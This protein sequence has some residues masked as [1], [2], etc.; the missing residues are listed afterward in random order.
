MI[1][2]IGKAASFTDQ[3]ARLTQL[4]DK[5]A[6]AFRARFV[7][8]VRLIR[9]AQT[10]T[11]IENLIAVGRWADALVVVETAML[12][13]GR[14][15]QEAFATAG[16]DTALLIGNALNI[17][18][19]FDTMND[20]ALNAMRQNTLRLVREFGAEQ[21]LATREALEDGIRRGINPR[22]MAREFRDSIGLTRR[23][24]QA[25]NNYRRLLESLD[26]DSLRRLLRDRRFDRT[27]LRAIEEGRPLSGKQIETMVE[28]Y[29]ARYLKYRSEVIG[30]TEAL[31]SVHAGADAMY[32]QAIADGTLQADALVR[33]W[34]TSRDERVR[35]SH[36]GMHD[37]QRPVGQPFMSGTGSLLRFPGDPDAPP[38]DTVQCRCAV[39]TRYKEVGFA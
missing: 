37:Q 23:Q 32:S 14:T 35:G 38:S 31:R 27:V 2:S 25:V 39:T 30:R 22:Q 1:A 3:H 11:A 33:Q 7:K 18:V 15:W 9:D 5:M 28:R 16:D 36:R 24:V 19:N 29:R 17:T 10:L 26:R 21:R 20:Y 4:A 8:I 12:Q 34:K 13:M 6:P